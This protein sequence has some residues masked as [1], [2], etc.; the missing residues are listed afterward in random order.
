MQAKRYASAP[1]PPPY[2]VPLGPARPL[3]QCLHS[4]H[5]STSGQPLTTPANIGYFSTPQSPVT[6]GFLRVGHHT[7]NRKAPKHTFHPMA[8]IGPFHP[9]VP[10]TM[11]LRQHAPQAELTSSHWKH[12]D[13]PMQ[14]QLHPIREGRG[15][16][17]TQFRR[18]RGGPSPNP[19]HQNIA[20]GFG[21]P[22]TSTP[23][24]F[25]SIVPTPQPGS[26]NLTTLTGYPQDRN[27]TVTLGHPGPAGHVPFP[28][29]QPSHFVQ[30]E[31]PRD[32]QNLAVGNQSFTSAPQSHGS[33]G[34]RGRRGSTNVKR[35]RMNFSN[36]ARVL[37]QQ[38]AYLRQEAS[39]ESNPY[40]EAPSG[41]P[42]QPRLQP[43]RQNSVAQPTS[44]SSLE[45]NNAAHMGPVSYS[46]GRLIDAER[47][48][49]SSGPSDYA[50][51]ILKDSRE[52][53]DFDTVDSVNR[54][55]GL[56]SSPG[57]VALGGNVGLQEEKA[58][59][60]KGRGSLSDTDG[61]SHTH[62]T[63]KYKA[64]L[65]KHLQATPVDASD[66]NLM[67]NGLGGQGD[68]LQPQNVDSAA[69]WRHVPVWPNRFEQRHRAVGGQGFS[70][71]DPNDPRV[72]R[73]WV[74][75]L[76]LEVGTSEVRALFEQCGMI[77][78]VRIVHPRVV[79]PRVDNST[80]YAFVT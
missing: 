23:H 69:N 78:D 17:T 74:G 71:Y 10:E 14:E 60:P 35:V 46:E 39:I 49:Q 4:G 1:Q 67:Y 44:P 3:P 27:S 65:T 26:N 51:Y 68:F 15:H 80:T 20:R 48:A 70:P 50:G 59:F 28:I 11:R 9:D 37:E 76:P 24:F 77:A 31:Y 2:A 33:Y 53:D 58:R 8:T 41:L 55:Q 32:Q 34:Q 6:G 66:P 29:S 61:K 12:P 64:L 75:N 79:Y 30:P 54:R 21:K 19:S 47:S 16:N 22:A 63:H 45:R 18:P 62:S 38:D 36:D 43:R 57:N 72:T 56:Q 25:D 13:L 52:G 73:I 40:E 42:L 5:R 7:W